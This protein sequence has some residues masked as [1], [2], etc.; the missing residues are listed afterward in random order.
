MEELEK[1]MSESIEKLQVL[2]AE[3]KL[4]TKIDKTRRPWLYSKD[5]GKRHPITGFKT[6]FN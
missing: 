6:K 5:E 3:P 1:L 4:Y 2:K